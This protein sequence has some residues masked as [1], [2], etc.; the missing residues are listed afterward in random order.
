[1]Q[2]R[3]HPYEGYCAAICTMP[4]KVFKL[5]GVKLMIL[6]NA[7]GGLNRNYNV[8]DLMVIK[9]HL[10]YPLLTLNHPLVGQNDTRFGPRF[11]PINLLYDK[12]MRELL[13]KVSNETN[14]CLHEGKR[15]KKV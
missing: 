13:K 6:T 9:D 3:F 1:M 15:M 11:L 10:S 12:D 5:L 4:I 2:G 7:A 8:G 14:V